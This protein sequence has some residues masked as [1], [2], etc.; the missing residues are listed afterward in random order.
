MKNAV[1]WDVT[2]C[3]YEVGAMLRSSDSSVLTRATSQKTEFFLASAVKTL[4]HTM[5][6][7]PIVKIDV[8]ND[9]P[10]WTSQDL[11][12][13]LTIYRIRLIQHY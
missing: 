12:K 2:P 4:D 11:S 7:F 13:R 3:G 10:R 1:F 9:E 6:T 5:K 8:T